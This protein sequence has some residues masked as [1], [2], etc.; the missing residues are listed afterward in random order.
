MTMYSTCG[1]SA[2]EITNRIGDI[3]DRSK[4]QKPETPPFGTYLVYAVPQG[5][6]LVD[7]T[8]RLLE[9][10]VA[11]ANGAHTS[12]LVAS[13]GL[14]RVLEIR[15]RS[16]RAVPIV[17]IIIIIITIIILLIS[18]GIN[19][20]LNQPTSTYTQ[21]FPVMAMCGHRCGLDMSAT[22]AIPLAV[23][24]GLARILGSNFCL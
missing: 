9:G 5:F 2:D 16:T 19:R 21:M 13:V 20:A 10:I 4:D 1:W 17:I 11:S 6:E 8:P 14:G 18:R 15:I 22:T 12:R 24:M 3:T 23:R 7:T